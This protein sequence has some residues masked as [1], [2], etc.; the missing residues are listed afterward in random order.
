MQYFK[1]NTFQVSVLTKLYVWSVLFEPLLYF[2]ILPQ[3]VT[4]VGGNISRLLQF[5][6]LFVLS[7]KFLLSLKITIPNPLSSDNIYYS[8]YFIFVV[9]IGVIGYWTGSYSFYTGRS[10]NIGPNDS[11][12]SLLLNSIR[13]IFEYF[14]ALYYFIYFVLLAQYMIANKSGINYFFKCFNIVFLICLFVGFTDL[15]LV[16]NFPNSYSPMTNHISS[17]D[18]ISPGARFH[19]FAGEPRDAFIYLILSIGIFTVRDI[20]ENQKRLTFIWLSLIL[21]ALYSTNAFSGMI[22]LIIASGLLLTFYLP[23]ISFKKQI[24]LII[25]ISFFLFLIVVAINSSTRMLVYVDGF[26][27]VYTDLSNKRDMTDSNVNPLYLVMNNIYPIWHLWLELK[28]L[29]FYHL[30]FGNGLGTASVINNFY[31]N[32]AGLLNPNASIVKM[33]YESGIIGIFL[34]I[35]AFL[36]PL[37]RLNLDYKIYNKLKFLMLIILGVYF[38]HRS[39]APFMFLGIALVTLRYKFNNINSIVKV[40]NNL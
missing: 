9:I 14:I 23:L 10:F 39:V 3:N 33:L 4:G 24:L 1:K 38:A 22:G 2:I 20:W 18:Y 7:I 32:Q 11:F 6:F 37:K 31:Y 12:F 26:L 36:T 16:S 28:E 15:F 34:F 21:F 8:Y 17:A 29:N 25:L 19:G 40:K 35:F 30:F 27:S 5:V 13:P